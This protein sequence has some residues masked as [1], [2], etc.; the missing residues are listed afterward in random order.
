MTSSRLA[1][2]QDDLSQP[3]DQTALRAVDRAICEL[4]RGDPVVVEDMEGGI[5]L[6][7]SVEAVSAPALNR[8]KAMAGTV[9][10]LA[11]TRPRAAAIGLQTSSAPVLKLALGAGLTAEVIHDLV[12]PT[13]R[14]GPNADGAMTVEA[15][16]LETREGAA[17]ALAKL[18]R[19]LPAVVA[20]SVRLP[21]GVTLENWL[22][23]NDLMMVRA[24]DILDY[25]THAA[26]T[27][28]LV[29]DASVP[30]VD[31]ENTRILAFRPPDGGV[32]HLAIVIGEPS[33]DDGPVLIRLH[34][35]CF[36]GDL[37]GSLRCDCGDQ[38]RGAIAEISRH[39]S[40]VV[41]YLA[42]EGR[43]IGLVNKLR[44][45]QLQDDG[46]DTVEANEMLGFDADERIYLPAAEMLRQLGFPQVRLLTN[47][48]DKLRQLARC[49]IEVV[50]RVPH[51]FPSNGHNAAY[52]RTKAER[53]GHM[54]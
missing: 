44:A 20:A 40:G 35:E 13:R 21:R 47:N 5:A 39:G 26:R 37:L 32:E 27:L 28:T 29:G 33:A 38:L 3:L 15:A 11:V 1:K 51:V 46:F 16:E 24:R 53:S 18:A 45:Y 23:K 6:A 54:F 7:L 42:Q 14:A 19:L 9:P 31:A 4:R 25:Q 36:T 41:L 22:D 49:G 10:V 48:P 52:L 30:L 43:G 8:I 12:D 17:V 2:L 50:D 34:S